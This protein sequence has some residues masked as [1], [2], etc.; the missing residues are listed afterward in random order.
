[1]EQGEY[2]SE[3]KSMQEPKPDGRLWTMIMIAGGHFAAIV[4]R[5]QSPIEEEPAASL[6]KGK[7]R[8][9]KQDYE[10][11]L[12]K[13]F[14]RYTS[15]FVYF[16]IKLRALI[17]LPARR[18][19][20]GSQSVNDNAKG[21]AKSAGAMLRRYGEQALRDDVR[22]LMSSPEWAAGIT[23]SE[24]IWIRAS[25]SNKRIFYDYDAA[26]FAK[27]DPRLRN[28]PFPT[29]RPTQSELIR[30]LGELTRVKV[31][32]FTEADL[33]EQDEAFLASL[34]KPKPLPSAA[35]IAP[36]KLPKVEVPKLTKEQEASKEKWGRVLEMARRGRLDV[37]KSFWD[38]ESESF[39]GVD[40][41]VPDWAERDNA[42][43][44]LLQVAASS[45]QEP[46]VEWLLETLEADPTLSVDAQ[47]G[48]TKT[49][50]VAYDLASNKG[51]RDAF[52]RAAGSMPDR[53][54]WLGAGHVP[55]VLTK[56]MET[57]QDQKKKIRRKGLK[58]KMKER[59]ERAAVE[60]EE[61]PEPAPA[62]AAPSTGPQKLG[63]N[64]V[65]GGTE[66]L[67]PEMRMKIERERR[68]RAI[69]ARLKGG[70]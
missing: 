9:P 39:G 59:E 24:R 36:P 17:S 38:R 23:A 35:S 21:P 6:R 13:T 4:V 68:A 66:G 51:V 64:K 12:H 63:G 34:P 16:L 5:I 19:Q 50:H 22:N 27:N 28:F 60:V 37:L 49:G 8:K 31:S 53:W 15:M 54:D 58:E 41:R 70:N 2:V 25:V 61:D 52:R 45:G 67:T 11:L 46:V 62:A 10:V 42:G 69:E 43:S 47:T 7:Q 55:S 20:G 48:T 57:E 26:A 40:A 29:R 32:H 30:C 33:R 56:E 44:T 3:L 65:I 14:H 18:K 1:M